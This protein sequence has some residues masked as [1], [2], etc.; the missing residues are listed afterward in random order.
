MGK[1]TSFVVKK[2]PYLPQ[3]RLIAGTLVLF[4]AV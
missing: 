3:G 2:C 4:N 1:N